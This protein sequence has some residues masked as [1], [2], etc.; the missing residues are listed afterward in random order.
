MV[1]I[2]WFFTEKIIFATILI[3]DSASETGLQNGTVHI[4]YLFWKYPKRYF[5]ALFSLAKWWRYLVEIC[6]GYFQNMWLQKG[7]LEETL[8]PSLSRRCLLC[9]YGGR[10][11]TLRQNQKKNLLSFFSSRFLVSLVKMF[12][13]EYS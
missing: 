3:S 10:R 5:Q 12:F 7:P 8:N 13:L 4:F 9:I 6:R 2:Q 11:L 1:G